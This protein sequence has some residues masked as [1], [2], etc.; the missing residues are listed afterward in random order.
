MKFDIKSV[1][2]ADFVM[3]D[4]KVIKNRTSDENAKKFTEKLIELC[5]EYG[6]S[7]AGSIYIML[8]RNTFDLEEY[9]KFYGE[10]YTLTSPNNGTRK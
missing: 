5:L 3:E 7:K 10:S 4:N 8:S 2:R 9:K 1:H 6:I